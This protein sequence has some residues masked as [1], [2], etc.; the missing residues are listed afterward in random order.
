[1]A[2]QIVKLSFSGPVHF[3]ARRLSDG[4]YTCDASTLFSALYIE[5]MNAGC[6]DELLHAAKTGD[7]RLSDAFPYIG[8]QLYIP[9]P[10]LTNAQPSREQAKATD[11]RERKA[12]KKLKYIPL[13][14]LDDY[15]GGTFDF[16]DALEQFE[17]G[18]SFARTKVNLTRETSD[19][20]E[21]YH[22]GAFSFNPGCGIYFVIRGSYNAA[23]LFEQLGYSGLG[24]K[25]TSGYGRFTPRFEKAN[26]FGA[27]LVNAISNRAMLLSSSLPKEEELTDELLAGAKYH[28][29]RKGGF[30]QSTTHSKTFQKKRDM[31]VF[32]PGSVF[33]RGFEGDVF[34][35]N[36]TPGS[37]SVYRYARAMWMEV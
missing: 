28:L 10:M 7:L 35:V 14:S 21:P 23:P 6:A 32:A 25:R 9:K 18:S 13:A 34:D 12:N 1:M 11:S 4:M 2:D 20:A 37:H 22:V 17:L 26:A 30:V 19:D 27:S 33:F 31:W 24:G 16:V 29:N 8:K 15:L 5:A 3:G 36:A